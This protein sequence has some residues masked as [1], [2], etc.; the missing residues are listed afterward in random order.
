MV[1]VVPVVGSVVPVSLIFVCSAIFVGAFP[2]FPVN[3]ETMIA[4]HQFVDTKVDE[5]CDTCL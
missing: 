1:Y 5:A 4:I 2:A 3:R